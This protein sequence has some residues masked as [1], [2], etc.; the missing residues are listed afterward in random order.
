MGSYRHCGQRKR[1][2][3]KGFNDI[4]HH[5]LILAFFLVSCLDRLIVDLLSK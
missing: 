1:R 3:G 2:A 4:E 5:G